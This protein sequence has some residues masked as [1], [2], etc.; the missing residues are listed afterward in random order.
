MFLRDRFNVKSFNVAL[1]PFR[2]RREDLYLLKR[3]SC[4][5]SLFSDVHIMK[6]YTSYVLNVI[7]PKF[8][9]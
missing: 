3:Y 5:H 8:N 4:Q 7:L 1:Q 6:H 9:L 2:I